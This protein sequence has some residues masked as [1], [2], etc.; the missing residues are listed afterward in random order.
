MGELGADGRNAE[1]IDEM[2]KD[3]VFADMLD[4]PVN[5][6][7]TDLAHSHTHSHSHGNGNGNARGGPSKQGERDSSQEKVRS[8]LRSFVR[9]WSDYGKEEREACYTPILEVLGREF[10]DER[11]GK[12]VLI[13]GC[14]LGRLA[15]EVAAM[16]MS[17]HS[18]FSLFLSYDVRGG[19]TVSHTGEVVGVDSRSREKYRL[20]I[21]FA[22]QANEYSTYMLI[23]SN[24]VL[25]QYISYLFQ[26]IY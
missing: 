13:P 11:G 6:E 7:N 4:P 12:K 24:F 22:A 25:N 17:L 23:A 26:E 16:G 19:N 10:P 3:P 18:V 21:G 5:D 15:M 2:I 8:T 20:I 1:F 14:G 9:D